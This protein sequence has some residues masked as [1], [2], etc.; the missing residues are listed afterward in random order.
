MPTENPG[1]MAR[2]EGEKSGVNRKGMQKQKK[3]TLDHK[4]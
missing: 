1:E 2:A 3:K 4:Q